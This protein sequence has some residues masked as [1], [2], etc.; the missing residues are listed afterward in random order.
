MSTDPIATMT[1][2]LSS[3]LP[4]VRL[5]FIGDDPRNLIRRVTSLL[6][7]LLLSTF[8]TLALATD[9]HHQAWL[10]MIGIVAGTTAIPGIV[11]VS[12]ST[13]GMRVRSYTPVLCFVCTGLLVSMVG[14]LAW[15]VLLG[16]RHL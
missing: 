16:Y 4:P 14:M 13:L 6:I 10:G 9:V 12:L 1:A 3:W 8:I 5:A 7:V 11:L 15:L 2:L